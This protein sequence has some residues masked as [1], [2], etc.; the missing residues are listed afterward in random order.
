MDAI[1][2]AEIIARRTSTSLRLAPFGGH[3]TGGAAFR[4]K[5]CQRLEAWSQDRQSECVPECPCVA[6]PPTW[7]CA[8]VALLKSASP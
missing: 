2:A 6:Y 3:L 5:G 1:G 8:A 7:A 4:R